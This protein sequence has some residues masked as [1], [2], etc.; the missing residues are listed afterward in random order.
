MSKVSIKEIW[1][2]SKENQ[3]LSL[4]EKLQEWGAISTE[5]FCNQCEKPMKISRNKNRIASFQWRCQ[6]K[7]DRTGKK[8]NCTSSLTSKT[9]F[10]GMKVPLENLV[11]FLILWL[12]NVSLTVI[13]D[14]LSLSKK[15]AVRLSR[16]YREIVFDKMVTNFE[17]IGG[18]GKV[19]EIDE[20][21]FGKRKY[22]RGRRVEGQWVFGGY[23]R[24]SGLIFMVPVEKRD[25]PTLVP[26]IHKW[27]KPGTTIMSDMWKSY[28]KLREDPK[29][30]YEHLT[31][32]H[33]VTFKDKVSGACTN[34]VEG[35]WRHAKVSHPSSGRRKQYFDGYL[36]KYMFLKWCK[37]FKKD[38]MIAVFEAFKTFSESS[39][40][41]HDYSGSDSDDEF[42]DYPM[43]EEVGCE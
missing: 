29:Y 6:K 7:N 27:I 16:F 30:K 37:Y 3:G 12:K 36:A 34:A 1:E 32:N 42:D 40:Q 39:S 5:K 38:P 8:C 23:E 24:G 28:A 33:S 22:N 26:L 10:E 4:V 13:I 11:I 43:E 41:V 9:I 15:T 35:S 2:L 21:K 14:Q 18:E 17:P 19:V 31:V 20:S 25:V